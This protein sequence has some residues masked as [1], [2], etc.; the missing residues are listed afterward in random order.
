MTYQI[1]GK[2]S[3]PG[4]WPHMLIRIVSLSRVTQHVETLAHGIWGVSGEITIGDIKRE[5]AQGALHEYDASI[6]NQMLAGAAEWPVARFAEEREMVLYADSTDLGSIA[7]G[8][9]DGINF[10]IVSKTVFCV[11]SDYF[12]WVQRSGGTFDYDLYPKAKSVAW[13]APEN[14]LFMKKVAA[15]KKYN[16]YL[17]ELSAFGTTALWIRGVPE[18]IDET[19]RWI[20][21]VRMAAQ[22][23]IKERADK[24]KAKAER[25]QREREEQERQERE[26]Q[27]AEKRRK[28]EAVERLRNK[29]LSELSAEEFA[30]RMRLKREQKEKVDDSRT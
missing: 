11:H 19:Y 20:D 10:R 27:E 12:I 23:A 28:D 5:L 6:W 14:N 21:S 29:P 17:S 3:K 2:R 1:Y 4:A 24:E 15:D 30:E 8:K 9:F 7:D 22:D 18:R 13:F 16:E 26:R 25:E